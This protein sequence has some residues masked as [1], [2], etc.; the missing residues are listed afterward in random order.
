MIKANFSTYGKYVTDSLYQWDIN[1]TLRVTGLN[2]DVVPEVHF[3]N[4]NTGGAIV[5][6]ATV[7]S[8]AVNVAIPNSLLQEPLKI[9]AHIGVYDGDAFK[10]VEVV[11]IPIIPRKKPNDYKIEDR[12]G[13]I[14]SF[15]RLEN[16]IK[17]MDPENPG[18]EGT[19]HTTI[20][21]SVLRSS[22]WL[23]N[24]YSFEAEYPVREYN[25]EISLDSTATLE[26]VEA[27][28]KANIVGSATT[29]TIKAYGTV[30]NIDIPIIVKAVSV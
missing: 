1:R 14:Y 27:F 6:Q 26:Q 2:L 22:G 20:T 28:N 18:G 21:L 5:R 16:M 30:P 3:S 8:H 11:E 15:K 13:E 29:N 12:D 19:S 9:Y 4:S 17:N 24:V 7:E 25:I 23:N 10:T